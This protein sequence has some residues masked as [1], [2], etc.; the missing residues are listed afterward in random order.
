MR[1]RDFTLSYV[2]YVRGQLRHEFPHAVSY[3]CLGN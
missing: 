2:A 1:F 3:Q